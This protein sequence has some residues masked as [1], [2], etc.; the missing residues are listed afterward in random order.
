MKCEGIL[1]DLTVSKL[2]GKSVV[3]GPITRN[4]WASIKGKYYIGFNEI[5]YAVVSFGIGSNVVRLF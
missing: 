3:K 5:W 1:A 2:M 4:S